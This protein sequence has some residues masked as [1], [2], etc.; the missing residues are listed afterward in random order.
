MEKNNFGHQNKNITNY[1]NTNSYEKNTN[2]KTD[3]IENKID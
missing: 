2:S 1:K 3:S